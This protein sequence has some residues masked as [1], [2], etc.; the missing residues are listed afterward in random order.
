MFEFVIYAIVLL[1]C[2]LSFVI[3]PLLLNKDV[4]RLS[5]DDTNIE[6]AKNKIREL[7]ADLVDGNISEADFNA[8][9]RELEV[10]LYHDL[11]AGNTSS[12]NS[13][14]GSWLAWPLLF[15]VPIVALLLYAKLGDFRAFEE[16]DV[17]KSKAVQAGHSNNDNINQMIAKLT[18][19]LQQNP[20]DLDGW[21]ML[22]RSFKATQRFKDAV[23]VLRKA[24]ELQA[25][26]PEI[27]LQ[28]ADAVAMANDGSLK[29]EPTDLIEKAL[30][31]QPDN[32]MGLWLSGMSKADVNDY[33][34][35]IKV[36]KKL[37]AHYQPGQ[38][39]YV[40]IQNLIDTAIARKTGK[41]APVAQAETVKTTASSTEEI[42]VKVDIDPVIK[43]K[44]DPADTV[45]VYVK[46]LEGP[47]MPLAVA[48]HQLKD[49]P[50][51]IKF[52][53]SMAMMPNLKLSLF[54]K[55]VVTAR[56]SKQGNAI[57]QPGEPIGSTEVSK[58]Q[59]KSVAVKIN[60]F[61]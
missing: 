8:A 42:M 23:A 13:G 44:L 48:K 53:D 49:L 46:A 54:D 5:D 29:G 45:F 25:N 52:D 7:K 9:K 58:Q 51:E 59:R 41:T 4:T 57:P 47:K 35:S 55:V 60:S 26:N 33:E 15:V 37:Q 30:K 31:I 14:A 40:E 36:W 24:S 50:L 16:V 1:L 19:R 11:N 10:G 38:E 6:L 2:A 32:L 34:G 18:Q 43:S 21:L 39:D 17:P 56:V 61:N 12:S 3:L 22:G 20:N 28:L 27:M